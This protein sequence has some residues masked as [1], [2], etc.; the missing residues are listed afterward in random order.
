[1][2]CGLLA[3]YL[4]KQDAKRKRRR[5]ETVWRFP[6]LGAGKYEWECCWITFLQAL[7]KN[8]EK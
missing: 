3:C 1:M 6:A 5:A 2:K 7:S 4:C 8:A